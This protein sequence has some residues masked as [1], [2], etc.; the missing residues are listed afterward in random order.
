MMDDRTR[1][2][3]LI[4]ANESIAFEAIFDNAAVGIAFTRNRVIER[5]NER[6]A[7]LFGYTVDQLLG[8]KARILYFSDEAYAELSRHASPVLS[9]SIPFR[10]EIEFR[11]ADDEGIWCSLYGRAIDP[12]HSADGTV[13]IADDISEL[14]Q[15]TLR[16]KQANRELEAV[17]EAA[18]H[19]IAVVRHRVLQRCNSR[20]EEIFGYQRGEMLD[21]SARL[22]YLSDE[23]FEHLGASAYPDLLAGGIHRREQVFRRRDGSAFWGRLSGRAFDNNHPHEG[24][25]WLLEDI[26]ER[27][28][29]EAR[30][31]EIRA[32]LEAIFETAGVGVALLRNR[33][34][35]QC[36]RQFE[37]LFGCV[38]GEMLGRSTRTWYLSEEDFISIGDVAYAEMA[39]T[40]FN[41]REQM[42]VKKDGSTFWGSLNGRT[43]NMLD[44]QSASVWIIDDVTAQRK[45]QEWL[46]E[47]LDEQEM[48]FQNAAV[49][50]VLIRQAVIQ[51]CNQRFDAIFGLTAGAMLGR[52]LNQLFADQVAFNALQ[53]DIEQ[54][55]NRKE[56]FVGEFEGRHSDGSHFWLRGTA[57]RVRDLGVI[58]IVEDITERRRMQE[59]ILQAQNELEQRVKLRTTELAETNARL[60]AEVFERM[61]A[62]ERVWHLAHHDPL[63]GLPNRSLLHDRMAQSIMQS[64]RDGGKSALIF[65]DL[66]NFKPINDQYGHDV[67]DQFLKTIAERFCAAVRAVD[68]VARFGGDEFVILLHGIHSRGDVE[69]VCEKLLEC[70][71][72]P[73]TI[74]TL[75]LHASASIGASIYPDDANDAS[76]LLRHADMA[77]YAVKTGG[78]NGYRLY[79]SDMAITPP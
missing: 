40:G 26:T 48:I 77:M 50:I 70:L 42:L 30:L 12:A 47:A 8:Q 71:H 10:T 34:L 63:T 16:E 6:W 79:A 54:A 76:A 64:T 14:R 35:V 55:L 41:R 65:V 19:G 62:E 49:G 51:R 22:W 53:P 11:R 57:H 32:Q 36:N 78:R 31:T 38:P 56:V 72:L 17:F 46:R 58:W 18:V 37:Q 24:T 66:D 25:V 4:G 3:A 21:R 2:P 45:Q 27:R 73:I 1:G 15:T 13:W 44:P 67:G 9:K 29:Q 23:D 69:T 7:S 43:L 61:Q 68:T 59:A 33:V 28:T 20:F 52:T 60:Q 39:Q 75:A 74:N 5:C